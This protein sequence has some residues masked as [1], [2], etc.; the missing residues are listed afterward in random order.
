MSNVLDNK[1]TDALIQSVSGST[2][3]MLALSL[4]Y[5]L[6]TVATRMQ[7][8]SSADYETVPQA[9]KHIIQE[10]GV[11]GLFSGLGS[12]WL[13]TAAQQGVYYYFYQRMRD[14]LGLADQTESIWQNLK[15]S[16]AAAIMTVLIV[17]PLWVI[18]TRQT[19]NKSPGTSSSSSSSSQGFFS[20][21]INIIKEEGFSSLYSGLLP[22]LILVINPAIQYTCYELLKTLLATYFLKR[23]GKNPTTDRIA[24]YT[25]SFLEYFLMGALSKTIATVLT[26]PILVMRSKMQVSKEKV[27]PAIIKTWAE[28]GWR[29]FFNGMD[30]KILFSVLNAALLMMFQERISKYISHILQSILMRRSLSLKK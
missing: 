4:V 16:T 10:E 18:S 3:G 29:G 14:R 19:V 15:T 27:V 1:R 7:V 20:T 6:Q 21:L 28:D 17:N 11:K 24:K 9:F 12:S 8:E 2:A 30:A 23:K 25:F 22:S 26:Y 5:P 13:A